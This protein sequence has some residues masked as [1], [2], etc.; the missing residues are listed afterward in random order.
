MDFRSH[1]CV[2][3][4]RASHGRLRDG[5][6]LHLRNSTSGTAQGSGV[7]IPTGVLFFLPAIGVSV[8]GHPLVSMLQ[9]LS[10]A[11]TRGQGWPITAPKPVQN[12]WACMDPGRNHHSGG[13]FKN[14][15]PIQESLVV[16][17]H[18]W[19]SES[20]DGPKGGWS[21]VV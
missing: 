20:I 5:R 4:G 11:A 2:W 18:E 10:L 12:A 9:I 13:S 17:N 7:A 6:Q 15:A 3:A 21:C 1:L 8:L 19:Q 14:R 16:V